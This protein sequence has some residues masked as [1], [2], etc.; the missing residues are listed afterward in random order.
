MFYAV[1]SRIESVPGSSLEC[2]ISLPRQIIPGACYLITRRC[3]QRS[4]L[5]RPDAKTNQIFEFCLAY[6]SG[7]F[8]VEIHAYCAMSNHYH[9]VVTDV[10]G[11]LP[12][13]MHWMNAYIAKMLNARWGRTESFWAPG[14]YSAVRLGDEGLLIEKMLYVLMNPVVAGLVSR[15]DDWP[16]A[17]SLAGDIGRL[18]KSVRRPPAFF[19]R[20]GSVP[21]CAIL[22][23]RLPRGID[24]SMVA[25]LVGEVE[26]AEQDCL[27][28]RHG[29]PVVGAREIVR[30]SP[31][32][33]PQSTELPGGLR[34]NFAAN[35]RSLRHRMLRE[36]RDFVRAYRD[37]LEAFRSGLRGVI[38]PAG[39]YLLRIYVG[40]LCAPP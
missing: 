38:F 13:F 40:V 6:A 34:P 12:E 8:G 14:S 11:R 25:R 23:L 35:D 22:E 29:Q 28:R 36:R 30:Q 16:G 1:Q 4:F 37:A 5:L 19:R 18:R 39:T 21:P 3:F 27:K 26:R 15:S 32:E 24:Q 7:R 2:A 10:D 33:S 31:L 9:L 17:R 20:S